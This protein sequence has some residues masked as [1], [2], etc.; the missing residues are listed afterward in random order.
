MLR[1]LPGGCT[2]ALGEPVSV[3]PVEILAQAGQAVH[4]NALPPAWWFVNINFHA[5]LVRAESIMKGLKA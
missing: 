5:D 3:L 1:G 2:A 4:P